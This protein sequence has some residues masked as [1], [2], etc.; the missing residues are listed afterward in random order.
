LRQKPSG[1]SEFKSVT[2][3]NLSLE[4][5]SLNESSSLIKE[6]TTWY[7]NETLNIQITQTEKDSDDDDDDFEPYDISNYVPFHCQKQSSQLI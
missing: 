6:T 7:K 4:E 3:E 2:V 5:E 1:Q